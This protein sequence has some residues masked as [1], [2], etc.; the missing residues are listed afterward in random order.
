M[1]EATHILQ[2]QRHTSLNRA[3]DLLAPIITHVFSLC[4][5]NCVKHLGLELTFGNSQ[6][7][8]GKVATMY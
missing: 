6:T 2:R 1:P 7:V 8:N 3:V 5:V 4:T